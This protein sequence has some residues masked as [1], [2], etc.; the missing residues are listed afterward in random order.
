MHS[1]LIAF[2]RSY[3]KK[4]S[5]FVLSL[6]NILSFPSHNHLSFDGSCSFWEI[7]SIP[8]QVFSGLIDD[9]LWHSRDV[10]NIPTWHYYG[11]Y[12]I[13]GVWEKACSFACLTSTLEYSFP[14]VCVKTLE[15]TSAYIFWVICMILQDVCA[16]ALGQICDI[17]NRFRAILAQLTSN[18]FTST[19]MVVY[20]TGLAISTSFANSFFFLI[21]R[22]II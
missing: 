18:L 6:D 7:L 9:Y 20:P 11:D 17:F 19:V 1:C 3:S 12:C 22:R 15:V 21:P 13:S 2:D 8:D 5:L 10:S 16:K 4:Y 14:T